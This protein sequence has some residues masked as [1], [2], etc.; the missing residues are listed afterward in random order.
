MGKLLADGVICPSLR[1]C[2]VPAILVL[3]KNSEYHMH[4]D[5]RTGNRITIK[6]Q[7]LI[8]RIENLIDEL[9]GENFSKEDTI[10]SKYETVMNG[11]WCSK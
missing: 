1:L 8:P 7:F 11:K 6:Y 5:N 2:A 4:V 3:K 10:K 9:T